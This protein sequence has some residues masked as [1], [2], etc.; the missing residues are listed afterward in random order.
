MPVALLPKGLWPSPPVPG[1]RVRPVA[2]S[3]DA[4]AVARLHRHTFFPDASWPVA[5]FLEFDKRLELATTAGGRPGSARFLCLLAEAPPQAPAEAPRA[6][7]LQRGAG[8][9]AGAGDMSASN[10]TLTQQLLATATLATAADRFARPLPTTP[11][12]FRAALSAHA[13]AAAPPRA[14]RGLRTA[15]LSNLCVSP[16]ARRLGV[17]SALLAAAEEAAA[18]W[19]CSLLALHYDATDAAAKALYSR[20]KYRTA[21]LEPGWMPLLNFRPGKRLTLAAKRLAPRPAHASRGAGPPA[22]DAG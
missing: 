8:G 1:L 19:G 7:S 14:A 17:A 15:Y 11:A 9:S 5:T 6:F 12:A 3:A 13:A 16:A 20:A 2:T 21:G 10:K 4:A 22:R 18:A